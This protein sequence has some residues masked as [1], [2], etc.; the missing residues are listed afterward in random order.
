MGAL[1]DFQIIEL[2]RD[3]MIT[4]YER[5]S[6]NTKIDLTNKWE[7][8]ISFGPSSYGYDPRLAPRY[9]LFSPYPGA[10]IDVKHPEPRNF[11]E[12]E[13]DTIVLPAHS[14]MLGSTIELFDIPSDVIV[15]CVGKSTYARAGIFIN[16]TPAEPQWKGE[17]T[18]EI[19]NLTPVPIKLYANEGICQLLFFRGEQQCRFTYATKNRGFPSKY[20]DQRGATHAIL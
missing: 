6:I 14:Y 4:P 20:Q 5:E 13:A 7:K 2:C 3:G 10:I 8:I 15:V 9:K 18:L 1:A 16:V 19:A 12:I 17:L 11:I